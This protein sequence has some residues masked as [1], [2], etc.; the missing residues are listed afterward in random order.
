MTKAIQVGNYTIAT[1]EVV[2]LL[3]KY[4]ILPQLLGELI[5]DDATA[6]IDC[7]A[8]EVAQAQQR[9]YA[10][11]RFTQETDVKAWLEYQGLIP[12]QLI[13]ILTRKLK[14]EKFKQATWGNKL[15]AYF[16]E[17]KGKLDK[18]IYS[19]LRTQDVGVVQELFFRIQAKEQSFAELARQYSL[20]PEAQTGGLVG[21]VEL[22]ALHPMMM[23]SL[24]SSQPGQLLPPSR[25]GEW[26]VIMRLE[27]FIPAQ[28]D[29]VTRVR[30]LNE[31]FQ[32]WLKERIQQIQKIQREEK[33]CLYEVSA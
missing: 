10:E 9:F 24:S 17:C 31:L 33:L 32:T 28:L 4:Q 30:L 29:E 16:L 12:E 21:P 25:V 20:G 14:I 2:P 15:E 5:L 23:Q 8:E 1:S 7:T 19:L 3:A 22:E 13:D 18:V 6:S 27:K 26:F 11:Y